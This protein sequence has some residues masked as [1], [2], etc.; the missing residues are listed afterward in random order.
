MSLSGVPLDA[1]REEGLGEEG[2]KEGVFEELRFSLRFLSQCS[3]IPVLSVSLF[4]EVSG[5]R[6]APR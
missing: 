3:S 6:D 5:S 1:G 4:S 2:F